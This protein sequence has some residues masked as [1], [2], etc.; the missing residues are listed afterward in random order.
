MQDNVE[1]NVNKIQFG[2]CIEVDGELYAYSFKLFRRVSSITFVA[3]EKN[4]DKGF[5]KAG[6]LRHESFDNKKVASLSIKELVKIAITL[7]KLETDP[8]VIAYTSEDDED[9]VIDQKAPNIPL[10]SNDLGY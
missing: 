9:Q 3:V 6:P 2:N 7:Y 5:I 8:E 1:Y 4:E 10:A